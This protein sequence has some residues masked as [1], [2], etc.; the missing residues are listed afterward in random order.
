MT[1]LLL[2]LLRLINVVSYIW[3]PRALI[4]IYVAISMDQYVT[5]L[6]TFQ[7]YNTWKLFQ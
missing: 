5:E 7:L 1:D 3:K 2:K 6:A 4:W